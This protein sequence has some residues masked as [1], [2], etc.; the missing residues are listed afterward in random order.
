M[1]NRE[2][3]LKGREIL[4][5]LAAGALAMEAPPVAAQ[6]IRATT[7][8]EQGVG[9]LDRVAEEEATEGGA[10]YISIGGQA[11][12][13]DLR[14]SFFGALSSTTRTEA[15]YSVTYRR[16]ARA[17]DAAYR[18]ALARGESGEEVR[19]L[20][21]HTHP[22]RTLRSRGEEIS[23]A[24][25]VLAER[26]LPITMPP[27]EPDLLG[28]EL[29]DSVGIAA[30]L[31]ETP[32]QHIE[33]QYAVVDE[34]MTYYYERQ[35]LPEGQEE[36]ARAAHQEAV[37]ALERVA[38][39]VRKILEAHADAARDA[40][41]SESFDELIVSIMYEDQAN[42]DAFLR[43]VGSEE[44]AERLKSAVTTV[45]GTY[46][47]VYAGGHGIGRSLN[48]VRST[49]ATY[50][51]EARAQGVSWEEVLQ[52]QNYRHLVAYYA[53]RGVALRA[54]PN[55]AAAADAPF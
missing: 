25:A 55:E 2:G 37:E 20:L 13:V 40:G 31:E 30:N 29:V 16:I 35:V 18:E 6:N 23:P 39:D 28:V 9:E 10:V 49:W 21:M 22:K 33:I 14:S 11:A 19:I 3:K 17:I 51:A 53:Q 8:W 47:A 42:L 46:E 12:F 43:S 27:S 1:T 7:T 48:D 44:L 50:V 26:G 45:R 54:V 4:A 52:S 5:A 34:L 24:I 15:N 38:S 36:R 32:A 41:I